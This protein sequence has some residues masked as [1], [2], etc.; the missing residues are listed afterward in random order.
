LTASLTRV[1]FYSTIRFGAYEKIKERCTTITH[2]PSPVTLAAIGAFSGFTGSV[3]GNFADVVCARMQNDLAHPPEKRYNYRNVAHGLQTMVHT[4]GWES[5]WRGVWINA[6][7]CGLSTIT[8]LAGYDVIKRRLLA[9]ETFHDG[10]PLHI[11]S[12]LASGFLTTFICNPID[13]IK[14][15]VLT[16]H[17]D[18]M[19]VPRAFYRAVK[20]EGTLW[21]F[22]G[23][24][25]ASISRVPS[26]II[27]FVVLEQLKALYRRENNLEE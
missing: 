21:M 2:A 12:S 24:L 13:V 19:S 8:M 22:K 9:T 11:T 1:A 17:S 3:I 4:E 10:V 16:A 6:S 25:P 7:R 26:T 27:I 20:A 14:A 15:R 5:I 23:L 18:H